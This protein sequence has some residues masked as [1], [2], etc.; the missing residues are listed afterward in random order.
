MSFAAQDMLSLPT[1]IALILGANLG[2]AINPLLEGATGNN[3]SG[4]RVPI[5]NLLNRVVSVVLGLLLLRPVA[6]LLMTIEPT[7]TRAVAD[8]H[9]AFNVASAL[10]FLPVLKPYAT[11]LRRF[12]PDRIDPADPSQPQY[13]DKGV[14]EIPALALGAAA[15][16]ALRMADVLQSMLEGFRGA[17]DKPDR[18]QI[19]EIKR[20]D[21]ILD[22][23]NAAIKTYLIGLDPGGTGH[24]VRLALDIAEQSLQLRLALS[25]PRLQGGNIGQL[26]AQGGR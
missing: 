23:L 18:R 16:E 14:R 12:L 13:L 20:A 4:L 9:T 24:V 25:Q 22:S 8:F 2:T 15:R 6:N 19:D 17:L 5:G 21:D 1:A 10:L 7:P 26:A 11:F 3:P